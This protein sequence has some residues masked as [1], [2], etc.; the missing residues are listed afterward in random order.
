MHLR[1][2]VA[3]GLS[4]QVCGDLTTDLVLILPVSALSPIRRIYLAE[5]PTF[6]G[7]S[8]VRVAPK[9]GRRVSA[10]ALCLQVRLVLPTQAVLSSRPPLC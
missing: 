7:S 4:G 9:V 8:S 10:V 6:S 2:R 1:Q 3:Q 5:S